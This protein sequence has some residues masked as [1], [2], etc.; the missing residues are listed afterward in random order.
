VLPGNVVRIR[1]REARH[2]FFLAREFFAV[3]ADDRPAFTC[4]ATIS[5]DGDERVYGRHVTVVRGSV[6]I[7]AGVV[8]PRVYD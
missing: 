5:R 8:E 4:H 2:C 1:G 6:V 3:T 7:S